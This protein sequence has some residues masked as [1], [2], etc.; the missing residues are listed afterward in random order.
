MAVR[1]VWGERER[2]REEERDREG[3][4][5]EKQGGEGGGKRSESAESAWSA[6]DIVVSLT[7]SDQRQEEEEERTGE[8][9]EERFTRRCRGI[10]G[11]RALCVWSCVGRETLLLE[12]DHSSSVSACVPQYR[13]ASLVSAALIPLHFL[14]PDC[15]TPLPVLETVPPLSL[16]RDLHLSARVTLYDGDICSKGCLT[17]SPGNRPPTNKTTQHTS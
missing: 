11:C 16:E 2:R 17:F 10:G 1:P 5:R 14:Q 12:L 6:R 7:R 9:R 8:R 3:E 15:Y 4:M 13:D